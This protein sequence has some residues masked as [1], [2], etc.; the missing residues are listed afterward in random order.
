MDSFQIGKITGFNCRLCDCRFN[1]VNAKDMHLKGRRHR[2]MYKKKVDPNL[3]VESKGW[4]ALRQKNKMITGWQERRKAWVSYYRSWVVKIQIIFFICKIQ[5]RKLGRWRNLRG[6]SASFIDDGR[7]PVA[8]SCVLGE[9]VTGSKA[10]R[11]LDGFTATTSGASSLYYE[12]LWLKSNVF[13]FYIFSISLPAQCRWASPIQLCGSQRLAT[14]V[15]SWR[16]IRKFTHR[17]R[18]FDYKCLVWSRD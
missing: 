17:Y 9:S 11:P 2:L 6:D 5:R 4:P 12:L 7:E 16:N 3:M 1:D 8:P 13:F 18:I 14:I 10:R 15:T